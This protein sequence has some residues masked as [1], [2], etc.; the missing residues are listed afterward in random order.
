VAAGGGVG[1]ASHHSLLL[2]LMPVKFAS[3]MVHCCSVGQ[4]DA[5]KHGVTLWI[6]LHRGRA[7]H[8][9]GN[10]AGNPGGIS[11]RRTG[12]TTEICVRGHSR[13]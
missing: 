13:I 6:G 10:S 2:F 11:R 7:R 9:T 8:R 1:C 4:R 3:Y 5:G 12:E